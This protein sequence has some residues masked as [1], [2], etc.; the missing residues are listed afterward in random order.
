MIVEH[1]ELIRNADTGP[2]TGFSEAARS[3]LQTVPEVDAAFCS[4][5]P[6]GHVYHIYALVAELDDQVVD[7]LM[8]HE[9]ALELQFPNLRLEFHVRAHQGRK[10]TILV[11]TGSTPL[12]SNE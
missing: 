4:L 12:L 7:R 8:V 10:T 1:P 9:S 3:R 5:D 2:F 6:L 11:P